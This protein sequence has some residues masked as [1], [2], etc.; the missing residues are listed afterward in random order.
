MLWCGLFFVYVFRECFYLGKKERNKKENAMKKILVLIFIFVM[1]GVFAKSAHADYSY[2]TINV[3]GADYGTVSYGALTL[4]VGTYAFGISGNNIVGG[5][6]DSSGSSNHGFIYNGTTYTTLNV[7]SATST[8]ANGISGNNILGGYS[9]GGAGL[10]FV[11]NGTTYATLNAP[12]AT[13]S[14]SANGISG[15]NIVGAYYNGSTTLGF[16]YDGATYTTLN[17]P[18]ATST[19]ANGISGDDIVGDYIDS[20][21]AAHGFLAT[22]SDVTPTPIPAAAYLFGSGLLGLVGIRKKMQK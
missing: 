1:A 9:N 12:G 18:G 20:N 5:Y 2:T 13:Y 7:P 10:G 6:T 21:G 14:T 15:N 11:Y 16:I 17:V 22:P 19:Y 4:S 3:P 8:Y